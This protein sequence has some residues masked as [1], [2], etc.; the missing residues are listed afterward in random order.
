V[1]VIAPNLK[2]AP[3]PFFLNANAIFSPPSQSYPRQVYSIHSIFSLLLINAS[4]VQ[5]LKP[6]TRLTGNFG[7]SLLGHR[8][9]H[10]TF[11]LNMDRLQVAMGPKMAAVAA[12]KLWQFQL[13]KENKALLEQLQENERR[14]QLDASEAERKLKDSADRIITLESRLSEV[15]REKIRDD[16]ARKEF[17]KADAAFKADFKNF[18]EGRLS[19]GSLLEDLIITQ[20][21]DSR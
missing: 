6:A 3:W 14:R 4:R 21:T 19:E 5:I 2:R 7:I 12:D 11:N 1:H 13:R 9:F 18:L 16:E 10:S 20:L 8:T 17:M 15:E